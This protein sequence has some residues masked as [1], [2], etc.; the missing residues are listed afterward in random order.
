MSDTDKKI[1]E[2]PGAQERFDQA[3]ANALRMPPKPHLKKDGSKPKPAPTERDNE[4]NRKG[5]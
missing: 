2:E 3:V 5:A 1:E 4:H